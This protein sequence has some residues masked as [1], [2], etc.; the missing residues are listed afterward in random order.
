MGGVGLLVPAPGL[1]SVGGVGLL[2]PVS[3]W[4]WPVSPRPRPPV[5]GWSWPVSP[6]PRPPVSGWSWPVSPCPRPPI[7]GWSWP[8]SPRP[9]PPVLRAMDDS[10]TPHEARLSLGCVELSRHG[11]PSQLLSLCQG[12]PPPAQKDLHVTH[13][14]TNGW[15]RLGPC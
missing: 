6:R 11:K 4:S 3:G 12:H 1:L 5:S 8:V 2:V 9:R 15:L 10:L 7:S 13:P 14:R